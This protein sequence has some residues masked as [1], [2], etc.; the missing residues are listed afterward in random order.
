MWNIANAGN[1]DCTDQL[2][3]SMTKAT[4]QVIIVQKKIEIFNSELRRTNSPISQGATIW[5][6]ITSLGKTKC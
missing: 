3:I 5:E 6:F 2:R 4:Q 1:H